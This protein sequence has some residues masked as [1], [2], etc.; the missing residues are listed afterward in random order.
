MPSRRLEKQSAC[1]RLPQ[2]LWFVLS[3]ML[4]FENLSN[5]RLAKLIWLGKKGRQVPSSWRVETAIFWLF[6]E[7]ALPNALRKG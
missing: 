5:G 2:M 1:Q 7:F 3:F 6:S 4:G